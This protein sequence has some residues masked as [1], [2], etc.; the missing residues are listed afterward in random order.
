MKEP[1]YAVGNYECFI[2]PN[3]EYVV[4]DREMSGEELLKKNFK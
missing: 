4:F 3:E 2:D 1:N